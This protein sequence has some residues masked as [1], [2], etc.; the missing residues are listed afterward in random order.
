M[1]E[2]TLQDVIYLQ[3][4]RAHINYNKCTVEVYMF[5]E[6]LGKLAACI[7]T[8]FIVRDRGKWHTSFSV[9]PGVGLYLNERLMQKL[10]V[11]VEKL[12]SW[13]FEV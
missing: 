12:F 4:R 5:H 8:H 2:L 3:I 7:T 6:K 1:T 13:A 9:S 10:H 11:E